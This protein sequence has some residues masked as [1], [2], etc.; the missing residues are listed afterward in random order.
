M[1]TWRDR[2]QFRPWCRSPTGWGG[3]ADGGY[4]PNKR[5]RAKTSKPKLRDGVMKRG[6]T[7]CLPHPRQGP[8]TG[9]SRPRRVGGF[10]T[11]DE[12]KAAPTR[13]ASKHAA[14][15]TSTATRSPSPNTSTAAFWKAALGW[16]R[17]HGV[18]VL[19][20]IQDAQ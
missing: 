14:V 3:P 18:C 16:R 11:E 10:P 4:E 13:R 7:W 5:K 2:H 15:S 12:A 19:R 6:G 20:P 1:N 8:E 9:V 17:T